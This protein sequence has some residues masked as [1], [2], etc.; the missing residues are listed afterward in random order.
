MLKTVS[1]ETEIKRVI[2][3]AGAGS[4][5]LINTQKSTLEW[6]PTIILQ[7]KV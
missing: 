2:Q 6:M 1:L 5:Q 4:F 3:D 7:D